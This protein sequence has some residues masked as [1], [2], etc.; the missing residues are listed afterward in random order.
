MKR[1]LLL[2]IV[3]AA[4]A[5][6]AQ[7]RPRITGIDHVS[8]YGG[9][10]A[11]NSKLYVTTLGLEQAP[12]LEAGT[13]RF[14]VGEQW[15]GYSAV[16]ANAGNDRLDHIAF[17]T[18]DGEALRRYLQAKGVATPPAASSR[19]DGARTFAVKDPEGNT[20]EFVQRPAGAAARRAPQSAVSRRLMHV[21]FIVRSREAEDRFYSE[22][23]GF[24]AYWHG[25]MKPGTTDWLA[26]QVPDGTDWLEYMLNQPAEPDQ[27][28][29]GILNHISLG[30]VDMNA[31]AMLMADH[32][33]H[34]TGEEHTQV[35]R[36]GK[37][38]LNVFDSDRTRVE[39]MEFRPVDKPC[40]SA[41]S[42]PHP[43]PQ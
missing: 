2:V 39:L 5:V 30:V 24:R 22:V 7:T 13:Q 25:G 40:C 17:V 19:A 34:E 37:L 21:G 14:V 41:Y 36:D 32:G 23:L 27:R 8:F 9:D 18:T 4:V 11:A 38:Q 26:L 12:A 43:R 10:P 1:W 28:L 16:P 20:I 33:W 29:L 42:G 31:A 35:G 6:S 15:V 3:C